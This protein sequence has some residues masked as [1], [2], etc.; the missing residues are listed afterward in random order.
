M[1]DDERGQPSTLDAPSVESLG[2]LGKL[3]TALRVMPVDNRGAGFARKV[4]LVFVPE[5]HFRNWEI[6]LDASSHT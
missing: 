2:I 4:G 5:L 1:A 6:T 3:Q